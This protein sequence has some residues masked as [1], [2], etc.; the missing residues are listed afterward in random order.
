MADVN[1][2]TVYFLLCFIKVSLIKLKNIQRVI[3]EVLITHRVSMGT[4]IMP[5]LRFGQE[6]RS[7]LSN[8][9]KG[10]IIGI[11]PYTIWGE[12]MEKRVHNGMAKGSHQSY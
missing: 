12:A 2:F 5:V 10:F 8:M 3:S 4:D 11:R 9:S 7:T 1:D 6:S